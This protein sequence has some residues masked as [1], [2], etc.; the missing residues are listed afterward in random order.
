MPYETKPLPFDP[1]SISGI[2]EKVRA[3][4]HGEV[5]VALPTA[6]HLAQSA[7]RRVP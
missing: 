5:R 3:P 4:P 2:S 1:K 6:R 7:Q